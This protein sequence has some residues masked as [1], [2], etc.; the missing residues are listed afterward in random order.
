MTS[1]FASGGLQRDVRSVLGSLDAD[2]ADAGVRALTGLVE[3]S[4]GSADGQHPAPGGD[5]LAALDGCARVENADATGLGL[6][7]PVDLV[8]AAWF[9]RVLLRGHHHSDRCPGAPAQ[10]ALVP[11][12]AGG[13]GVQQAA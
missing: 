1:G 12:L 2:L 10:R 6:L 8:A 3:V 7:D 13:S 9:L 5:D 4:P 11:Q